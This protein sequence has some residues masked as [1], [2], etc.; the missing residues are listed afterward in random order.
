MGLSR[1]CSRVERMML[2]VPVQRLLGLH[3]AH[4]VAQ[5]PEV[6]VRDPLQ[7]L[8]VGRL[9]ARQQPAGA[10]HA[11]TWHTS[12]PVLKGSPQPRSLLGRASKAAVSAC[13]CAHAAALSTH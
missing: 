10:H 1:G 6:L 12:W 8:G 13:A 4:L 3:G 9:P 7:R 2:Q 11:S 5:P